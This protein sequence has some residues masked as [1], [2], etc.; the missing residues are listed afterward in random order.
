ML[1]NR[2]INARYFFLQDKLFTLIAKLIIIERIK[3]MEQNNSLE[4]NLS[5]DP[6]AL[7][8]KYREERD[9]RI[10]SDGK[11]QYQEMVGEFSSYVEDPYIK[12]KKK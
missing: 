4:N 1:I 9:K 10:R 5:F 8:R 3:L 7:R 2:S 6:E 11:E 12:E